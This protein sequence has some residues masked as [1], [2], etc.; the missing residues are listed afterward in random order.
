MRDCAWCTNNKD[1]KI[2]NTVNFVKLQRR[3]FKLLIDF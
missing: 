3:K 1:K 2:Q